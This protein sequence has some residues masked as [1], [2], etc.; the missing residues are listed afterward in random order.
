MRNRLT[1]PLVALAVAGA[2]AGCNE[3]K[4][5]ARAPMTPPAP[6]DNP[7][8]PGADKPVEAKPN[9]DQPPLKN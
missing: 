6:A 5:D 2:L 7:T 4:E 9:P 8:R 3:V 1:L